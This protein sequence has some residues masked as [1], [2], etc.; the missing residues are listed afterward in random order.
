MLFAR[1]RPFS[2]AA[3]RSGAVP[4]QRHNLFQ[5]NLY[6][7]M[8]REVIFIAEILPPVQTKAGERHTMRVVAERNAAEVSDPI[9]LAVDTKAMQVL[10]TPVKSDLNILVELGE[11]GFAR[12]QET[13]PD[14][15]LDSKRRNW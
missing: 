15:R 8:G 11:T 7:P 6:L 2:V 4:I 9:I 12:N 13:P 5:S 10:A 14:Q 1:C 3:N